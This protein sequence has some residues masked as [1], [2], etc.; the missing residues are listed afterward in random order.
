METNQSY[1]Q[2]FFAEPETVL[3]NLKQ[4]LFALRWSNEFSQSY[5]IFLVSV[6]NDCFFYFLRKSEPIYAYH[7]L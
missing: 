1:D 5:Q 3:F 6:I 4:V 7:C 2:E